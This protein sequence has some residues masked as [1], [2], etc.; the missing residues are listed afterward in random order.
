MRSE[1]ITDV[2]CFLTKTHFIPFYLYICYESW[3]R[4]KC[5][6]GTSYHTDNQAEWWWWWW[7]LRKQGKFWECV[8]CSC[9]QEGHYWIFGSADGT[10]KVKTSRWTYKNG[11]SC[12]YPRFSFYTC[13][14]MFSTLCPYASMSLWQDLVK[15]AYVFSDPLLLSILIQ[16][17]FLQNV[18]FLVNV[19]Q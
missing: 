15:S 18:T 6:K 10:L 1:F 17:A 2:I 13:L 5:S 4:R 7:L 16:Y 9:V 12:V 3:K 11:P 19:W 8:F 14:H